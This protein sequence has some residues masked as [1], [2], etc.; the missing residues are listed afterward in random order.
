MHVKL[1]VR[2]LRFRQAQEDENGAVESYHFLG[3][4]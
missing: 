3:A 2:R 4:Q 1:V